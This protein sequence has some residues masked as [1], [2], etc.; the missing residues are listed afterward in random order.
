MCRLYAQR[1]DALQALASKRNDT[2]SDAMEKASDFNTSWKEEVGWL[3][4]AERNAYAD[5]K[6]SGLPKTC[7]VDI[8]KHKVNRVVETGHRESIPRDL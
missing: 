6:P 1:W 4:D 3:S 8:H 7:E 2:L 5:W